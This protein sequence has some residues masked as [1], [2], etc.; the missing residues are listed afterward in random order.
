MSQNACM[1]FKQEAWYFPLL[2]WPFGTSVKWT[3]IPSFASPQAPCNARQPVPHKLLSSISIPG[4]ARA[5]NQRRPARPHLIFSTVSAWLY[6]FLPFFLLVLRGHSVRL[7]SQFPL[8][9]IFLLSERVKW[10][11]RFLAKAEALRDAIWT[12]KGEKQAC[13]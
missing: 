4:R 7:H 2:L 5:P 6:F 11:C 1:S 3:Y 8:G 12:G 10:P 9:V 13:G